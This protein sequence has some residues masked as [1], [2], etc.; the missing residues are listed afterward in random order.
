VIVKVLI[1]TSLEQLNT[2][3]AFLHYI[4]E[5]RQFLL[6]KSLPLHTWQHHL[7]RHLLQ[8]PPANIAANANRQEIPELWRQRLPAR[9]EGDGTLIGLIEQS[10]QS[11]IWLDGQG[12]G[13]S[14]KI[15][16]SEQSF[17]ELR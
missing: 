14:S 4:Q 8:C 12:N 11:R 1:Q 10:Q 2:Y 17:S 9:V 5:L 15:W 3:N 16:Y 7:P 13:Q 6:L